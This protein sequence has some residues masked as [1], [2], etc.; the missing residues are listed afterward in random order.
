[1]PYAARRSVGG[2]ILGPAV[3]GT[4]GS[5]MG[6]AATRGWVAPVD[7]D[8]ET[9]TSKGIDTDLSPSPADAGL[10]RALDGLLQA[11]ESARAELSLGRGAGGERPEA[12]SVE[13]VAP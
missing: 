3:C 10:A 13:P 6:R 8:I 7:P 5:P 1:V 4:G 2:P 12:A 9:K 11:M